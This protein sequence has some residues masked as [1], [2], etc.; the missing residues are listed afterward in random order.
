MYGPQRPALR[1][2]AVPL[3]Y[4]TAI[5]ILHWSRVRTV[6]PWETLSESDWSCNCCVLCTGWLILKVNGS[7]KPM[8][9]SWRRRDTCVGT[10]LRVKSLKHT[11]AHVVLDYQKQFHHTEETN[12][13]CFEPSRW[14]EDLSS[15]A[16]TALKLLWNLWKRNMLTDPLVKMLPCPGS[17]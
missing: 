7:L 5:I 16:P 13:R 9:R 11:I 8:N 12:T 10:R 15:R 1:A 6:T 2:P 4:S 3:L 14:E 17:V